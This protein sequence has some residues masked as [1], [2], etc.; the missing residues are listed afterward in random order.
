MCKSSSLIFVLIFAFL[1]KLEKFS[2]RLVGVIL[3]IV[4]GVIMMVATETRF[5][6]L[7]F[8]LITSASALS[9]LRW[10]LTQ[11]LLKSKKMG[12]NTPPATIFW[13]AP[14]MGVSLAVVSLAIDDWGAIFKSKFFD[15][16]DSTLSTVLFLAIPGIMAFV[17]V[18]TEY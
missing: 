11:L 10:S 3:L 1:F 6:L 4:V 2:L 5:E 15:G 17:M 13:L 12:M 14:V 7:G 18:L 8:I 16:I 9:G